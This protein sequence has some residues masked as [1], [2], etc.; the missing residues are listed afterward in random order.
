MK[1]FDYSKIED[2]ILRAYIKDLQ[3]EINTQD[4][5]KCKFKLFY[6]EFTQAE[7]NKSVPHN[8]DFVPDS[9]VQLSLTGAGSVTFNYTSF[10]K[11]NLDLTTTDACKVR[12]LAGKYGEDEV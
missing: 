8:L 1:K 7:T 4:V 11:D 3:T 9:I 5:L 12:F 6:I 10:D 2:D